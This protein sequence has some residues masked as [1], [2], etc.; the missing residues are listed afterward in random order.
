MSKKPQ[1]YSHAN[2]TEIKVNQYVHFRIYESTV[3]GEQ[4]ILAIHNSKDDS[5]MYLYADA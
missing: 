2:Y 4:P 3:K 5:N 1:S